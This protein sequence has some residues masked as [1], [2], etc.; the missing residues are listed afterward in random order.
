VG[1]I[2]A[3][4]LLKGDYE[5]FCALKRRKNKANQTQFIFSPQFYWGLKNQRQR[6]WRYL[7]SAESSLLFGEVLVL[8]GAV[9]GIY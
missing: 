3:K 5:E 6:L 2:G 4:S 9:W 7:V 8:D 1:K